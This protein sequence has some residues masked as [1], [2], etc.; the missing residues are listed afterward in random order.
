MNDFKNQLTE[1]AIVYMIIVLT[2][3]QKQPRLVFI[4][5]TLHSVL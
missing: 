1:L 2:I 3:T 4:Q 5:I